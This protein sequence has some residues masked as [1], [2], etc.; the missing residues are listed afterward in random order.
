M[1]GW[2]VRQ[3]SVKGDVVLITG[4]AMGIGRL[5]SLRFAALGAVVIVW[6]LNADLGQRVVAEIAEIDG[7]EKAHFYQVDVTDRE[8]VYAM[9]REI[10]DIFGGV[11][12][13]INNA[14]I[15][16]GAPILSSSDRMIERT[17]NVNATSHFWTIK[18]FLPTMLERN[19]GHIVS[20]SS[21]AALFGCAGMVDYCASKA[22]ASGLMVALRQEL[23]GMGKTGVHTT[24]VCPS[25]IDT[26]MFKGVK[27]P[28]M[29]SWL[30]PEYVADQIVVTVRRNQWRLLTPSLLSVMEV[31]A[32]IF[33]DW[34]TMA[35]VRF[36][37]VAHSMKSFEQT[38]P[39]AAVNKE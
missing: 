10:V 39:H 9:G 19:S 22:A 25:F 2:L 13:L 31:M 4:G 26:G 15:V 35:F 24:L 29:T 6:D 7:A 11:D 27:P 17:M 28:R 14:G 8:S 1:F 5:L 3:K 23:V 18:A 34:L 12:I 30:K 20:I 37:R 32:A 38:R 16:D 33:P 21:A 36:M